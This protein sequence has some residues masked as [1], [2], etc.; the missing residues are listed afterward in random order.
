MIH[1]EKSLQTHQG[2]EV[3]SGLG[4]RENAS[5]GIIGTTHVGDDGIEDHSI[6]VFVVR[7]S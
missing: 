3:V 1:K 6:K 7:I 2:E 5:P 4:R